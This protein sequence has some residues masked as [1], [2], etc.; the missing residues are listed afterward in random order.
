MDK[1]AISETYAVGIDMEKA[2]FNPGSDYDIVLREE[3]S[4]IF[5]NTSI[6]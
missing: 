6:R 4:F 1:L 5:L 3:I 2:L